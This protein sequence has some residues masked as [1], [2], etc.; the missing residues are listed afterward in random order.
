VVIKLHKSTLITTCLSILLI[1]TL[2][3]PAL[4]ADKSKTLS[5]T[6]LLS[7][8][9]LKFVSAHEEKVA[10]EAYDKYL[11]TA[12][13]SE[14]RQHTDD[15]ELHHGLSLAFSRI[16]IGFVGLAVFISA[17]E[18]LSNISTEKTTKI[19]FVPKCDVK[20][21]RAIFSITRRF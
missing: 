21:G 18:Q 13:Q 11:H 5:L 15:Y 6:L 9:A 2:I 17:A 4:A 20:N 8:V 14:M 3:S 10:I 7:G 12:V 16:G 1:F 19:S